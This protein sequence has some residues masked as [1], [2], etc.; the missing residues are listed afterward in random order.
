MAASTDS[1]NNSLR[2]FREN[3]PMM[4]KAI[5]DLAGGARFWH[6]SRTLNTSDTELVRRLCEYHIRTMS[7]LEGVTSEVLNDAI[8][9][10]KEGVL[11]RKA[12]EDAQ[13]KA[14]W[15]T[16]R[17]DLIYIIVVPVAV[18]LLILLLFR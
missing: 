16:I 12:I 3:N 17:G 15:K 8:A 9:K 2:R 6:V 7:L 18:Q 4:E 13:R 11:M 1:N 5:S 10:T 14:Y